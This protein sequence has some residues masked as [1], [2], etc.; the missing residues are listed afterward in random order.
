VYAT[1]YCTV[2]HCTILYFNIMCLTLSLSYWLHPPQLGIQSVF[3][4]VLSRFPTAQSLDELTLM[5]RR[6]NVKSIICIGDAEVTQTAAAVRQGLSPGAGA[7]ATL[8][9][10]RATLEA[11]P[12]PEGSAPPLLPLLAVP[13]G[14][15][16]AAY[17][18]H[19]QLLKTP[20]ADVITWLLTTPPDVSSAVLYYAVLYCTVLY[21]AV[22][23]YAVLY[24]AVLYYA[25]L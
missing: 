14:V 22:L 23:Y 1:L 9:A 16:P 4:T 21:Y 20:D 12:L 13:T 15:F 6:S 8:E 2:L 5:A 10:A 19:A 7:G 11:A 17:H 24:Y 25:V 3:S 18:N